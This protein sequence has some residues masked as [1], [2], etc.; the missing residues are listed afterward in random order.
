[1][2][3]PE[4]LESVSV[5]VSAPSSYTS[6]ITFSYQTVRDRFLDVTNGTVTGAMRV[7]QRSEQGLGG[8]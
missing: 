8:H 7:F 3:I 4:G 2:R 5:I 1:M 6:S